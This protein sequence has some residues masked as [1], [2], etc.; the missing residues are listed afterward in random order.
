MSFVCNHLAIIMDGNGRWAKKKGLP[1]SAG[2]QAGTEAAKRIVTACRKMGMQYVTLYAFS[3]ENWSRPR[4]E[5]NFLFDLLVRFLSQELNMLVEQSIRLN[6]LGNWE[7]MPFAVRQA[8]KHACAKSR[9]GKEMVLNM[10]LNY[11][12][13]EEILQACR[14]LL[15]QDLDPADLN[16]QVFRDQLFTAGQADPDLIIRTSGELRLSNYLIFQS[17]YSEL[18]FTPTLWPDFDEEELHLALEDFKK[19]ERRFG[20]VERIE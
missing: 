9:A 10:A 19:R 3:R 17:A 18:Y 16:E 20:R 15:K 2:H 5:I 14:N 8:I 11:S 4:E 1:R 13:R 12:G 7:E 6:I